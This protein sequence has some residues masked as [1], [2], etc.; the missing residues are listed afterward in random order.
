M[1][2]LPQSLRWRLQLWH[3][4]LLALVVVGFCTA[5]WRY[6]SATVLQRVQA[7]LRG[8]VA[9]AMR[10]MSGARSGVNVWPRQRVEMMEGLFEELEASFGGEEDGG[11]T[12]YVISWRRDGSVAARSPGTPEDIERPDL[13][14]TTEMVTTAHARGDFQEAFNFTPGGDCILVGRSMAPQH[15]A[16]RAYAW[17]MTLTGTV[18]LLIGLGVGGWVTGHALRPISEIAATARRIARGDL[19]ERITTRGGGEIDELAGVLNETFGRL[20]QAFVQ[21]QQFTADAAHE[22]R[23]PT[24]VILAQ[25]QSALARERDPRTYRAALEACAQAAARLQHLGESLIQLSVFDDAEQGLEMV[26]GDL[27]GIAAG[28]VALL[29]PLAAARGIQIQCEFVPTPCRCSAPH[30]EQVV[31]NLLGNA[32]RF[33]PDNAAIRLRT[34]VDADGMA[35]LSVGDEGPGIEVEHLDRIF[36]RFYRADASRNRRLGGAGLGLAICRSI[37][38]AYGGSVVA[39]S[40]PGE[41]SVF[42]VRLFSA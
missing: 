12:P 17:Q 27:S 36:E 19:E 39:T 1:T 7:D 26:D 38:E 18:V 33:S 8:K 15:A 11:V 16:L 20:Q 41:G 9:L 32:I 30:I 40:R 21:Q 6:E 24:A 4:L 37:V 10:A 35:T 13:A 22:L 34:E 25:A 2:L 42:T 29:E 3:G 14:T 5:A 28:A 23:T 31:V